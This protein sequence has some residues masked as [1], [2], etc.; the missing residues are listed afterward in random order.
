M[1]DTVEVCIDYSYKLK[2][3][4]TYLKSFECK[5]RAIL[6]V[7]LARPFQFIPICTD[8]RQLGDYLAHSL[9]HTV[10]QYRGPMMICIRIKSFHE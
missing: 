10:F 4:G 3:S 6:H 9:V 2:L 5:E 7:Y 8:T 1:V